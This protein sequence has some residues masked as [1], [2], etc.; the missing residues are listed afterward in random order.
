[1]YLKDPR[2]LRNAF[3]AVLAT[4]ALVATVP[5]VAQDDAPP[6]EVQGDDF[7]W[8]DVDQEAGVA[9]YSWSATVDN[10][11]SADHEVEVVLQLLDDQD[12][13]QHEEAVRV[14][15]EPEG[16]EQIQGGGSVEIE[17]AQRVTQLRHEVRMGN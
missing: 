9:N 11:D 12:S 8:E 5:A 15:L 6:V 3:V 2:T 4:L 1:M 14:E 17:V 16:S 13:V 7:T 10:R